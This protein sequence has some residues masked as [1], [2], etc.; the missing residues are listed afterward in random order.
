MR[1]I[2][3]IAALVVG[4][5][6]AAVAQ[7]PVTPAQFIGV[8]QSDY[9]NVTRFELR[10]D[11]GAWTDAGKPAATGA[12]NTVKLAMPAMTPGAHAITVRA[13]NAAGCS[14]AT[15][16]FSVT[17]VVIPT[18]PANVRVVDGN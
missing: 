16:P 10:V 9:A 1:H 11:T 5:S 6:S 4:M 12:A 3:L 14:A 2:G 13:C 17:L 15:A 8:D 18:V 7:T